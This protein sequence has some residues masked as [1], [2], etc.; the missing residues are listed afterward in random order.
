MIK[1][2]K[3]MKTIQCLVAG[4]V[5]TASVAS[6]QQ[7]TI[8]RIE[9]MPAMPAPY[10][11]RDWKAVARGYDSLVFDFSRSG[12]YLPLVFL[13]TNTVNYPSQTSFGL[14][15]YVGDARSGEEG[16]A[17][18]VLPALNGAT[19]CGVD[20]Q[21]QFGRDWVLMSCEYFN[22]RPAENVYLNLP[23]TSSGDD[24]WYDVMPNI[25]FYQ[26]FSHY[27]ETEY[28]ARQFTTVADRWLQAM[29]AMRGSITPWSHP[30]LEHRGWY[31]ATMTPNNQ[32]PHE[33]EA[34][35]SIAW[36]LYHASLVT[37][38]RE[39][40]S[41][42]ELFME[43]LNAYTTNPAYELQLSYGTCLAARMNAEIGTTFDVEKM[44]NW[45]FDVSP[46]RSWGA[47][48]GKWGG[49]DCSG[50]IGEVN[51]SSDYAFAMNTFEQIGALV[52]LVRYDPRFARSIGRW[53]LNAAN[54]SR[55][56]YG[57]FLPDANQDS[58]AW[59]RQY[60]SMSVMAHEALRQSGPGS[61][62]PY[63]TGDAIGGGWAP[64]N[65]SLYS[66]SHVGILGAIIDTTDVP[67]ILKLDL[68]ATD[69]FGAPAYRSFLFY[70]PD[71]ISHI[72]Q[73]IVGGAAHDVYDA[74]T[75]QFLLRGVSGTT[76]LT[77]PANQAVVAV[78]VPS[79]GTLSYSEEKMLVNGVV[80]DF[81]SGNVPSNHRP[82]IKGLGAAPP[83]L[84]LGGAS[85]LYC[86]AVD[87]DGDTLSYDWSCTAGTLA[88]AGQ[89]VSWTA[90]QTKG[91]DTITCRVDD[92]KGGS[93][94]ASVTVAVVDSALSVPVIQSLVAHPGKVDLG[95]NSTVTC[96]ATDPKGFALTYAWNASAGAISGNDTSVQWTAPGQAGN[97]RISCTVSNTE[98]GSATDSVLIPVRDFSQG[99]TGGPILSLP[100]T[101]TITDV[102]GYNN[103]LTPT[104]LLFVADRFGTANN[105]IGFN[106]ST[107]CLRVTNTP[108]L[109]CD[110]AITVALWMMPGMLLTREMFLISHGSWQNRWKISIIPEGNIRWTVKT[111]AG[112][113]DIDSRTHV[114]SSVYHHV[115]GTFNGSDFE[116][117]VDGELETFTSFSGRLLTPAIDLTVGQMLPTDANY[118]FPGVID[119]ILIYNYALT[120]PQVQEVYHRITGVGTRTGP[121]IPTVTGLVGTFP[122]PFNPKAAVSFQLSAVSEVRLVVYDGLGREVAMLVNE[123]KPAGSY[124]VTFDG[125]GLASGVYFCRF[126]AGNH[127]EVA[128]ML[129]LR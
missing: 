41:A 93:D 127:S 129:L 18:N 8:P 42:A 85:Q 65:L 14:H 49:Y 81:H 106:G 16:E 114:A 28:Y 4:A 79:G 48:V 30:G 92:G 76:G 5:M 84:Y 1:S 62:S 74:V 111:T 53:V 20:K 88:G 38:N 15:T 80:V 57:G 31:L 99:G 68:L 75:K 44:V 59:S 78:I 112:V 35:G 29:Y 73:V 126:T 121:A 58:R 94:T 97:Y 32:L 124:E 123:R 13:N 21:N 87:R 37:G 101:G 61:V 52:P 54:A 89:I 45:C 102:S 24:W 56:F 11:M 22:N 96:R 19:L 86:T 3:T 64:T 95:G 2:M 25:F 36:L 40:R 115:A 118:N 6:A 83:L 66:S 77:I 51:G 116:L 7:I 17:I 110:S 103:Q 60:D 91:A 46:I 33:P 12:Q 105:A 122:N 90:P 47:M 39:Y 120:Y 55:L 70:N 50:L 69:Y 104:D 43:E 100:F 63:A 98:G 27:Q 34:G 117:Y 107:S 119:D 82:R 71:T 9:Q 26:L 10:L 23:A 128:K 72:V 113:R 67:G 125:S 109:S 108:V